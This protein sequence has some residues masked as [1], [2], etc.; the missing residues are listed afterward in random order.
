MNIGLPLSDDDDMLTTFS[1]F[2]MTG[3]KIWESFDIFE[4]YMVTNSYF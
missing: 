3:G 1:V 4:L 2:L